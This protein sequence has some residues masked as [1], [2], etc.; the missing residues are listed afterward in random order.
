MTI[1]HGNCT[2]RV[3]LY[4]LAKSFLD[5]KIPLWFEDTNE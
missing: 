3:T 1:S 2:K 4:P 5:T